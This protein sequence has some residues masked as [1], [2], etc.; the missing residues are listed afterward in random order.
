M[1]EVTSKDAMGLTTTGRCS[2]VEE[3]LKAVELRMKTSLHRENIPQRYRSYMYSGNA[4]VSTTIRALR[5]SR[6][7][8]RKAMASG[9]ANLIVAQK[10]CG[11]EDIPRMF[12]TVGAL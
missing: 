12:E 5:A 10:I 6:L 7:R 2:T 8:S 1:Q 9:C 4:I 3:I 11:C